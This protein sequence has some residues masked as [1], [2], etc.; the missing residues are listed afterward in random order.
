MSVGKSK[1]KIV[2]VSSPS[3]GGK[4]TICRKLLDRNGKWRFSVSCTTRGKRA[5]EKDGREYHFIDKDKF[6]ERRREGYFAESARVHLYYYGTPRRPLE[7]ALARGGVLILDVDVKGA[8]SLK[9]KYPQA[10]G[11]FIQPPSIAELRRR[12]KRRGTETRE[13]MQ[14]RLSNAIEEMK[15]FNRFDYVIVNKDIN[16]AVNAA[17]HII[18]SWTVGSTFFGRNKARGY[19]VPL[20]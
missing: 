8:A 16:E 20:K 1:G 10:L 2:I 9:R 3:G 12:L 6:L 11:I 4:T 18:K 13:Q 19:T 15:K 17:D 14:V 7:E 5:K